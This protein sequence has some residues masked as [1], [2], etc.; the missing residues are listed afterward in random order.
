M[1]N[2]LGAILERADKLNDLDEKTD[3][4]E[5]ASKQ[6]KIDAKHLKNKYWWK[7]VKWSCCL[8]LTFA[9]FNTIIVLVACF[10]S[11]QFND[12]LRRT[13]TTTPTAPAVA[14]PDNGAS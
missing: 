12:P 1:R 3:H 9:I 4:L 14:N 11:G 13:E 5:M 7:N 8:F 2:N 10:Y 6:F